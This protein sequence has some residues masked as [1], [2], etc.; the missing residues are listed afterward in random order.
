VNARY[1]IVADRQLRRGVGLA[2]ALI[3]LA[4][5][6]LLLTAVAAAFSASS[7]AI[8]MND[9]FYRAEQAARISV[10]QI[11]DQIRKC[12]SGTVGA[13]SLTLVT[14]TGDNR[15]YAL[16]GTN[17]TLTCTPTGASGPET[18]TMAKNIKTLQFSTD[19]KSVSMLITVSVGTN[20][21]TLCGSAFPRRLV[22]YQ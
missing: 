16:S 14:D 7:A 9:E 22:V 5:S 15:T 2:E 8:E 17:L 20:Q 11:I 12:Q 3:S 1:K 18:A 4:I 19:G 21:A 6:A 13:T 10:N